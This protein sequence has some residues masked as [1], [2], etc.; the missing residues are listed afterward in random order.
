MEHDNT[1]LDYL[2]VDHPVSIDALQKHQSTVTEN[3]TESQPTD[4]APAP[5]D[6][7]SSDAPKA[8]LHFKE[9]FDHTAYLRPKI[10]SLLLWENPALSGT[11][12]AGSLTLVL[13]CRWVNLLNVMCALFVFGTM[14]LLAY[15]NG[16]AFIGRVTGKSDGRPL[17]KYYARSTEYVHLDSDAIHRRVDLITDGLNVVL[18]ELAKVVLIQDNKRSLKYIGIFYGIWTLRTWF[19]TTTLLSLVLI[20]LFAAPRLYL[21]NQVIVDAHIAKTNDLLQQHVGKGREIANTHFSGIYS[22]IE[23]FAQSKGLLTK[24]KIE[25]EEKAE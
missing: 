19:S 10:K 17:E 20:S 5:R 15:V 25:K 8:N 7:S 23:L 1:G 3:A 24:K 22:S 18:T 16:L 12:L 4:P 21:D 6:R 14:G 9:S 13:S 11:V 2:Q